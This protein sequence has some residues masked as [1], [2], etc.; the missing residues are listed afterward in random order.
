MKKFFE[1]KM[2]RQWVKF[3]LL[4]QLAAL[5]IFIFGLFVAND[6]MD[7]SGL[8]GAYFVAYSPLNII[9]SLLTGPTYFSPLVGMFWLSPLIMI[10]PY[11]LL[12][13]GLAAYIQKCL[14]RP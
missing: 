13:G 11:S 5:A 8:I 3:S 6:Y 14:K 4:A 1:E 9:L 12:L 2:T 7:K 10:Y